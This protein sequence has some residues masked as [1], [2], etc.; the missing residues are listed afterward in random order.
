[1]T[2]QEFEKLSEAEQQKM[3]LDMSPMQRTAMIDARQAA[4]AP[5]SVTTREVLEAAR[6]V[7]CY[8]ALRKVIGLATLL[9]YLCAAACLV[10]GLG[11][12]PEGGIG[13]APSPWPLVLVGLVAPLVII[14]LQQ[15]SLLF[16]DLVDLQL[17][18]EARRREGK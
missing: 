4:A 18:N 5:R 9:G 6:N 3:W 16:V 13:S 15:S 14:V 12:I 8:G 17:H 11:R 10:V 1:M 2:H 7:S